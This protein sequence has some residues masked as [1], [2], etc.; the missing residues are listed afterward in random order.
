MCFSAV[1]D[2]T[3]DTPGEVSEAF[4]SALKNSLKTA[5]EESEFCSVLFCL[6]SYAVLLIQNYTRQSGPFLEILIDLSTSNKYSFIFM[7]ENLTSFL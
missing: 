7:S 3:F 5:D 6:Y 4:G 2:Y 1:V